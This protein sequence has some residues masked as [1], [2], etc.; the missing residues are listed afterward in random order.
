M[1]GIQSTLKS[2]HQVLLERKTNWVQIKR[3]AEVR[4]EEINAE[5]QAM[6][7]IR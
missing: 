4:L 5:I 7:G 6:G 2:D 3:R 1:T